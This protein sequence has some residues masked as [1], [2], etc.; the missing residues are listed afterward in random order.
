LG[1]LFVEKK[2]KKKKNHFWKNW[3]NLGKNVEMRVFGSRNDYSN[4]RRELE[5]I[6][7][8][9]CPIW[10]I[11]MLRLKFDLKKMI[12]CF[13]FFGILFVFLVLEK[14]EQSSPIHRVLRCKTVSD[15]YTLDQLII[16]DCKS[17]ITPI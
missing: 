5:F 12:Y 7:G 8:R 11:V 15:P 3:E 4:Q 13:E 14:N 6:D 1:E 17:C 10:F 16:P 9:K 2:R